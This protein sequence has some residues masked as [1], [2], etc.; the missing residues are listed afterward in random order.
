MTLT[1]SKLA[2]QL[3][4]D[5]HS[6]PLRKIVANLV[7]TLATQARWG[8]TAKASI[9]G[10]LSL[11]SDAEHVSESVSR[12]NRALKQVLEKLQAAQEQGESN[13]LQEYQELLDETNDFLFKL[14]ERDP[15]L[16]SYVEQLWLTNEQYA[17]YKEGQAFYESI[18][19]SEKTLETL[20]E[21]KI[22][23][24][25]EINTMNDPSW[26]TNQLKKYLTDSVTKL[27]GEADKLTD[28][29]KFGANKRFADLAKKHEAK[30]K[31]KSD[32]LYK[33]ASNIKT[34][35]KLI[36]GELS[37]IKA[38]YEGKDDE[39]SKIFLNAITLTEKDVSERE[40]KV[41]QLS[42]QLLWVNGQIEKT[43]L[44]K[45]TDEA[46]VEAN[47]EEYTEIEILANENKQEFVERF[48]EV[49][50]EK[51][52]QGDANTL[53]IVRR[54]G[55]MDI[56]IKESV[57]REWFD[58]E[59]FSDEVKGL[60]G[61]LQEFT[62]D[63]VYPTWKKNPK[64]KGPD[65]LYKTE[66]K[67]GLGK[68]VNW[69]TS[70]LSGAFAWWGLMEMIPPAVNNPNTYKW[71]RDFFVKT[72]GDIN[73]TKVFAAWFATLVVI[74]LAMQKGKN[75]YM[76]DPAERVGKDSIAPSSVLGRYAREIGKKGKRL[77][78]AGFIGLSGLVVFLDA[79]GWSS[80]LF[81][82][83]KK[84]AEAAKVEKAVDNMQKEVGNTISYVDFVDS[85]AGA[86]IEQAIEQELRGTAAT[87][88]AGAG[89]FYGAKILAAYGED[90]P[91]FASLTPAYQT[92]A[93][94]I[95]ASAGGEF[96]Q[97]ESIH[98]SLSLVQEDIRDAMVVKTADGVIEWSQINETAQKYTGWLNLRSSMQ[99]KD[100]AGQISQSMSNLT[101]IMNDQA[102][103]YN[104]KMIALKGVFDNIENI[105]QS[106]KKLDIN[107]IDDAALKAKIDA[108]EVAAKK[109]S[110]AVGSIDP[111]VTYDKI[112][113]VLR[114]DAGFNQVQMALA[115]L[116]IGLAALL[117]T[118]VLFIWATIS[119]RVNKKDQQA[120]LANE[121]NDLNAQQAQFTNAFTR[122]LPSFIHT[123]A[124]DDLEKIFHDA[125]LGQSKQFYDLIGKVLN[126]S[127]TGE[128]GE[129]VFQKLTSKDES[130]QKALVTGVV[131]N[132]VSYVNTHMDDILA[133][134][135]DTIN[136]EMEA[137]SLVLTDNDG[138][139]LTY[140]EHYF[141]LKDQTQRSR[142]HYIN[143]FITGSKTFRDA[144]LTG[145]NGMLASGGSVGK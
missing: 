25:T 101:T 132:F 11:D 58:D 69:V 42:D 33:L 128:G 20:E 86:G 91:R 6:S 135:E 74:M 87:G 114:K 62:N 15:A 2:H 54:L 38:K 53:D 113:E 75:A 19:H 4:G 13:K 40:L 57:Q 106:G 117:I 140:I 46:S 55:A 37:T 26:I 137:S 118:L 39:L 82:W 66:K 29:S 23:I 34:E 70:W 122:N 97:Y 110:D 98:D 24:Q 17:T 18:V 129:A 103:D 131:N 126:Q 83:Y 96:A 44:T 111:Y 136:E 67:K 22:A 5:H 31:E 130:D 121:F 14:I 81:G 93:K 10:L 77:G 133:D 142:R 109:A 139:N 144:V 21:Q 63:F 51:L 3:D 85:L 92:K 36:G 143:A 115:D 45:E 48:L 141:S 99:L 47:L 71:V 89:P 49:F 68:V 59:T 120:E 138:D 72:W 116:A 119:L 41:K 102:T 73:E 112:A 65:Y 32:V 105:A 107:L 56:E 61:K 52:Q 27:S 90:D 88:A 124:V 125:G 9:A 95:L 16:R 60:Y 43:T 84:K 79:S 28:T 8:E 1:K 78:L 50:Q 80:I 127:V 108:V 12:F 123:G 76:M 100:L 30:N 104:A 64:R 145:F 35:M 94:Q 134:H 7:D